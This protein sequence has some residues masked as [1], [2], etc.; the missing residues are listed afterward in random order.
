MADDIVSTDRKQVEASS[1]GAESAWSRREL[2]TRLLLYPTH[3][4][5]TAAAPVLVGIGLA[6]RHHVYA[7]W[8][9]L[10]A[11]LGSWLIHVAGVFVD[12]HE[13]LRQHG[14][15][16]EH[17]QLLQALQSGTLSLRSL[18]VAILGCITAAV[19]AGVYLVAIGGGLALLIGGIGIVASI[20]Y[21]GG[22]IAYARTGL[23]EPVFFLMFGVVAITG[24]YFI[25][26]DSTLGSAHNIWE[27]IRSLPVDVFVVGL[28][29]GALITNVLIIDDIR[30]V[31]FD[32]AKGW[33]TGTVRFGIGCA[34]ARFVSLCI[35]AYLA[36]IAFWYWPGYGAPALLP[37]LTLPWAWNIARVVWTRS[38]A[39]TLLK[40]TPQASMLSLVYAILLSIGIALSTP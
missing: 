15:I 11:F 25:Q 32:T 28:P 31:A 39:S 26:V 1:V 37:L 8:A 22:P 9:A 16:P 36:P 12:N 5:P 29:V 3:T 40:M 10:L 27:G 17:P 34:R 30:D 38:D 21:A 35:L 33:R 4:L 19:L 23:A 7:P 20:S 18:Q 6:I 2:W 13:L 14:D 24:T